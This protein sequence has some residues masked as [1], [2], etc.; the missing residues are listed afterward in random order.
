VV[1]SLKAANTKLKTDDAIS[2]AYLKRKAIDALDILIRRFG[3]ASVG[4]VAQAARAAIF[5]W[6]KSIGGNILHWLF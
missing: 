4:L 1:D 6:L 3:T 5:D 2:F